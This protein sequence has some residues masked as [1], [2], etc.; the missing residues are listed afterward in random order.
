VVVFVE[1]IDV[2]NRDERLRYIRDSERL[3]KS[4]GSTGVQI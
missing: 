3:P 1:A 2:D 4:A